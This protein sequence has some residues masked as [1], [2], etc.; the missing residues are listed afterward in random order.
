MVLSKRERYIVAATIIAVSMLVLDR[1]VLTPFLDHRAQIEAERQNLLREMER[2]M[3]HFARRRQMEQEWKEMLEAGLKRDVS[4]A[5]S[6][7]LHA[8]RNWSQESGFVLSS[9]KPERIAQEGE[10]QEITFQAAGTGS[11]RSV[12]H[13]LW[14][15][16]TASLPL[17][18]KELQ[19]GSRKEGADD[20]SLQVRISALCLPGEPE[21]SRALSAG[22]VT[23]GGTR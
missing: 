12:A 10:L 15:L 11:M 22:H 3:N 14:Q 6:Q 1:Y 23:G 9:V 18:L 13:F 7:V 8:V 5:E 20:L 2:A 21:P 19:L 17:K 4:E 16:E